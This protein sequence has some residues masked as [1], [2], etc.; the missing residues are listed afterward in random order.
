MC[1][2]KAHGCTDVT[3]F[4]I[5]GHA[6]NL[7]EMQHADVDVVLHTSP[8]IRGMDAIDGK[9]HDFRL[10]EGF[11]AET[12]GGLLIALAA[13]VAADFCAEIESLVSGPLVTRAGFLRAAA[14]V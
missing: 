7:A 6:K 8:I 11:S 5:L 9:V 1:R 10:L 13:D 4:G 3:G 2:Y 14:L 12:S